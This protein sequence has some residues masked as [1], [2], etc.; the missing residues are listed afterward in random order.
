MLNTPPGSSPPLRGALVGC[1]QFAQNHLHAWQQVSGAALVAV[2]DADPARAQRAGQQFGVRAAYTEM[3]TL[4]ESENLDFVD[5]ATRMESHQTLTEQAARA[6]VHV[7]CQKPLAPTLGEART[8][9]EVCAGAGVKLLVHE[10]FRFQRPMRIMGQLC[11][12]LGPLFYGRFA[13]RTHYDI[14][15]HQPYL[16]TDSRFILSDVG[17]HLFDLLRYFMGEVSSLTCLTQQVNPNI[18]G[19]D[20][21]NV[22]CKLSSGASAALELSYHSSCAADPFPQTLVVLEG[23]RGSL[24][25]ERD[26]QITAVLD[27]A[28]SRIDARPTWQDWVS[29]PGHFIQDSVLRFQQHAVDALTGRLEPETSGQD[30]LRTLEL[31]E[32]AYLSASSNEIYRVGAL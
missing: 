9:V 1:G 4:L 12:H 19:E 6:G 15:A 31:V 24:T 22:L 26:G 21:A 30:N 29:P 10:N 25:L 32:G 7:L 13:F 20:V 5:I 28:T 16:A 14:Y 3:E 2:C 23:T 27:G 18:H 11:G 8:M 17:V